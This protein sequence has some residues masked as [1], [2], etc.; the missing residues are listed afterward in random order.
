M[1]IAVASDDGVEIAAH[2]GRCRGF[3]IFDIAGQTATRVEVRMNGFTAHARGMCQGDQSH[4]GSAA[5]QTHGPL[6][7]ALSDCRVLVTRGLGQRLVTDLAARGI[8][9]FVCAVNTV[10]EAADLYA[11]GRLPRAPGG[12]CGCH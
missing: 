5:H 9:A 3:V 8:E 7:A 11:R 2:T 10:D 6:V 4:Q 12:V 1:R